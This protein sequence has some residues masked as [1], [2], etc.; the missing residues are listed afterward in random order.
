MLWDKFLYSYINYF[1]LFMTFFLDGQ[2]NDLCPAL[3]HIY[4]C[5]LISFG[6]FFVVCPFWP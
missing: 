6:Q 3:P 4:H 2:L 1:Y 5:I